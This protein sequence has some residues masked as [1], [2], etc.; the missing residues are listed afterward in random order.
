MTDSH[1]TSTNNFDD[2]LTNMFMTFFLDN[3][4]YGIDVRYVREII[5]I[6]EYT[7]MPEMP[8]YI[9][10]IINMRGMIIPLLDVRLRFGKA[11]V[12]YTDRTCIIIIEWGGTMTGLIVDGVNEVLILNDDQISD[13]PEIAGDTG[14]GF[15]RKIGK[16]ES[17][18]CLLLDSDQLLAG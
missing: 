11:S 14:H 3:E 18:V 7:E 16:T 10:G 8:Y 4:L 1:Q 2:S 17:G 13:R 15:V 5:G 12:D 9:K 6:Q